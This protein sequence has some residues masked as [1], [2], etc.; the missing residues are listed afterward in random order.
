MSLRNI[1][2]FAIMVLAFW[3]SAGCVEGGATSGDSENASAHQRVSALATPQWS[4][5]VGKTNHYGSCAQYCAEINKTCVNT[6]TTSRGFPNWG[7][8]AW[9]AGQELVCGSVGAGQQ[10]C[11]FTWDD[12]VG[13]ANRWKCCCQ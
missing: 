9:V 1:N 8:E 11:P 13:A 5:F 6:C 12:V 2:L 3:L 7:V 10:F 4:E